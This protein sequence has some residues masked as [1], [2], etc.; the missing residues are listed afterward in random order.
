MPIQNDGLVGKRILL[1]D[2]D[3]NILS[4]IARAFS[5]VG[6]T[7]YTAPNGQAGLWQFFEHEPDLVVL[8]VLMPLMDGWETC[9]RLRQISTVP[10]LMLTCVEGNPQVIRGLNEG[11]DDYLVKPVGLDLLVAR[12]QALLRRTALPPPLPKS[13]IY[14]DGYLKLDRRERQ[15]WLQGQ[16]IELTE[17]EYDLL[18][19]LCYYEDQWRSHP[20][21]L[22]EVWGEREVY[23]VDVVYKNMRRLRQK[24]EADPQRPR[25]LLSKYGLGYRFKKKNPR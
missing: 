5:L 21:I 12:V 11:A 2:D 25:Y 17:T 9:R 4:V 3:C 23:T 22:A 15:I 13:F 20:Q 19:Y 10:I 6:C 14:D 18:A 16:S 8:D 1:I 7:V 24:L